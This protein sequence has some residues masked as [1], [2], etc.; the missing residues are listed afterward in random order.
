MTQWHELVICFC[1]IRLNWFDSFLKKC[2]LLTCGKP[3]ATIGC[4]INTCKNVYHYHCA[5]QSGGEFLITSTLTRFYCP[6]HLSIGILGNIFIWTLAFICD[7]YSIKEYWTKY[8]SYFFFIIQVA[9]L[10]LLLLDWYREN[11]VCALACWLWN[12]LHRSQFL[13]QNWRCSYQHF[14]FCFFWLFVCCFWYQFDRLRWMND[15]KI[16]AI[17]S[18]NF[19]T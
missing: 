13:A 7:Q 2:K 10:I 3:R 8:Q 5:Y 12:S 11:E 6:R 4:T 14:Q 1:F 15:S 17:I 19:I 16:S 18:K 9:G